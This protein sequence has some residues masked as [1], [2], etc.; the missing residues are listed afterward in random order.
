[1][2]R[3]NTLQITVLPIRIIQR[4]EFNKTNT[5]PSLEQAAS[6]NL[7]VARESYYMTTPT[8]PVPIPSTISD[9]A[10][11]PLPISLPTILKRYT[12]SNPTLQTRIPL[13]PRTQP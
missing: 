13:A 6:K 2:F 7:Y 3:Y 9:Y 5:K 4:L 1:M 11:I 10:T 8:P 12:P